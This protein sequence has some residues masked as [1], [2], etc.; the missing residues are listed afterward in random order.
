MDSTTLSPDKR[1]HRRLV[2]HPCVDVSVLLLALNDLTQSSSALWSGRTAWFLG[3][4]FL[5]KHAFFLEL[6][7]EIPFLNSHQEVDQLLKD[8]N[9]KA[10]GSEDQ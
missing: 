2:R 7:L 9:L 3:E 5:K 1:T 8:A 6:F 10:P 4:F